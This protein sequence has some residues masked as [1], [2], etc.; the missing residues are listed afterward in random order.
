M[1]SA[2]GMTRQLAS[3]GSLRGGSI[4]SKDWS[5]YLVA[6]P[7]LGLCMVASHIMSIGPAL[8]FA[9]AQLDSRNVVWNDGWRGVPILQNFYNIGGLDDIV[10]LANM[11]FMPAVYGY[12]STS[13]TQVISF[14]SDGGVV[15][16][17]WWLES[18]RS[19]RKSLYLQY[20]SLL[21][22]TGQLIGLGV[23]AP[24]YAFLSLIAPSAASYSLPSS[25]TALLPA[26]VLG[27]YTP[28]LLTLASPDL[29]DRQAFLSIWQLFPVWVSLAYHTIAILSP[30]PKVDISGISVRPPSSAVSTTSDSDSEPDSHASDPST[31][32][33]SLP[34]LYRDLLLMRISIGVPSILGAAAWVFTL[35][36][37]RGHIAEIF[38]PTGSPADGLPSL[39]AFSAQFLRWD[40][41]F[42]FGAMVLWLGVVY[43]R[44]SAG[45][46]TGERGMGYQYLPKALRGGSKAT[47]WAAMATGAAA[48]GLTLGPGALLGLGWWWREEVKVAELEKSLLKIEV[49]RKVDALLRANGA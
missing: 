15:L 10:S 18:L 6:L 20:P 16:A 36:R 24:L 26:L 27:F 17:I 8:S 1:D 12:D 4:A 33:I 43:A 3:L 46:V 34:K 19:G 14:L 22:L 40:W 13:R 48:T 25:T 42:V 5:R 37:T 39:T 35:F 21:A 9:K 49:Q 7:L 2:K 30:T 41:T 31:P 23:V 38:V 11:F 29:A 28:T 45:D 32:S 44:E 47:G